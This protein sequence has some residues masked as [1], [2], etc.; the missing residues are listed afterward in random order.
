M[1]A[2]V[3]AQLMSIQY[4]TGTTPTRRFIIVLANIDI[5]SPTDS[6]NNASV[7]EI[8]VEWCNGIIY[9][10]NRGRYGRYEIN[11]EE[12]NEKEDA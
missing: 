11:G 5:E 9:G 4:G 3:E 12:G 1:N 2:I 7:K 8:P 6:E 10:A